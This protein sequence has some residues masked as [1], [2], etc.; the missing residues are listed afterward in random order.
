MIPT[1]NP[2]SGWTYIKRAQNG[3]NVKVKPEFI[4]DTEFNPIITT[5]NDFDIVAARCTFEGCK[6][7]TDF[8]M[9]P[10]TIRY[11]HETY[12]GC[13]ALVDASHFILPQNI[14]TGDALFMYCYGLEK[15]PVLN[16]HNVLTLKRLFLYCH[17]LS[18]TV[19]INANSL[20]DVA[21]CF[22]DTSYPITIVGNNPKL[23]ELVNS[24]SNGNVTIG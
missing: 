22:G 6:N 10:S 4:L 20:T 14:E 8:P 1:G 13:Q 16:T 7:A 19:I 21:D 23:N 9:L 11:M 5:I 15:A 12:E 17:R 3:W 18:G 2:S 24:S